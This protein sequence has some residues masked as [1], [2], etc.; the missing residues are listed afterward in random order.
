MRAHILD[1]DIPDPNARL[2]PRIVIRDEVT[3]QDY[4]MLGVYAP[5]ARNR[6]MLKHNPTLVLACPGGTGTAD[7]IQAARD[8]GIPV[9]K[10]WTEA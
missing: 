5:K 8:K 7:M 3:K 2:S 1:S 4:D 10:L 6:R 9:V